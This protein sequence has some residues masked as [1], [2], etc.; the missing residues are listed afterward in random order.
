[1]GSRQA[2]RDDP[3]IISSMIKVGQSAMTEK[4]PKHCPIDTAAHKADIPSLGG[5]PNL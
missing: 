1:M 4:S 5:A 2:D 3:L